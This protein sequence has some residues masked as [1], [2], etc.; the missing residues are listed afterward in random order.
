MW[1]SSNQ[2]K[3]KDYGF[4]KKKVL[5]QDWNVE[6][7]PDLPVCLACPV[8]FGL[9][10]ATSVPAWVSSLLAHPTSFR[11]SSTY[12]HVRQIHKIHLSSPPLSLYICMQVHA[13][14]PE[15]YADFLYSRSISELF[16]T[17]NEHIIS[18][19]FLLSILASLLFTMASVTRCIAAVLNNPCS[20]FL[21]NTPETVFLTY[22]SL[23][24]IKSR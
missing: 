4:S 10:V 5:S 16:K 12:N 2:L 18:Q 19:I 17:C 22:L 23:N 7:L 1:A 11:S 3:S 9:K 14:T 21:T 24:Q 13:Y 15:M 8:D 20:L 6:N